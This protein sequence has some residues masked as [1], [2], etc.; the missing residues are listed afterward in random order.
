MPLRPFQAPATII[1][2]TTDVQYESKRW[3][4]IL[5]AKTA[6]RWPDKED[7]YNYM[8]DKEKVEADIFEPF[9]DAGEVMRDYK[10]PEDLSNAAGYWRNEA[11]LEERGRNEVRRLKNVKPHDFFKVEP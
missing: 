9:M 11:A 8:Y 5:P 7:K 4:P 10:K 6:N 2:C 3:V 1:D